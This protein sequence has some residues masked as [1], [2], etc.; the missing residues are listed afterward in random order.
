MGDPVPDRIEPE[1]C[2]ACG[3]RLVGLRSRIIG[4]VGK[5]SD[6]D[7]SRIDP[8][9]LNRMTELGRP[10][11]FAIG[12]RQSPGRG[13][14]TAVGFMHQR[15]L[16]GAEDDHRIDSYGA[17]GGCVA[18]QGCNDGQKEHRHHM[19]RA[20]RSGDTEELMI[21]QAAHTPGHG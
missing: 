16:V 20:V 9:R 13:E 6:T 14:F 10:A 19:G 18:R 2:A 4:D 12:P 7:E 21:E 11:S 15:R 3:K 17:A 1:E 5:V 8:H